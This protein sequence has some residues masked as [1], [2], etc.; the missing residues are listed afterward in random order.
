ME[1]YMPAKVMEGFQAI[2]GGSTQVPKDS[3]LTAP[4]MR[5]GDVG[6]YKEEA[7]YKQ[8]K[9][10]FGDW[11]DVQRLGDKRDYCRM[12]YPDG[13]SEND[14][15]FACALAGT[16]GMSSISYRTKAVKDGFKRSRDDYINH[17]RN[18]GRDAY[19]RILK[20]KD[21][22]YGASCIPADDTSFGSSEFLDTNPPEDIKTL[23]DF[24]RGCRM[25][26]RLRDDMVDYMGTTII[27]TAGGLA[28]DDTPRPDVTQALHFNGQDQFLRI[29][30]S[31]DLTL[32]N[33]GSLRSVRA[34]SVWV[35]FDEFTNNAH[36]FDFGNGSGVDNVFLGILG[37]G[38]AD[39]LAGNA[40]R[41]PGSCQESTIP[42]KKS[43]A[44]F[45]P[46]LSPQDLFLESSANIDEYTCDGPEVTPLRGRPILLRQETDDPN[47]TRSRATLLFEIWDSRIRKMQIKLNRAIPKGEWT[48]IVITAKD[49]DALRPDI[50][51]YINGS[52]FYTQE[53]GC[54]P[55][56]SIT[57]SNYLGKSNWTD[58]PGEY[59]LRD[60]LF[61]GSIFDFRVYNTALSETK[62]KRVLQWGMGNL[63]LQ[64]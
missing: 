43:G 32:G 33:E 27:Q 45:C 15:F 53:A 38:D 34:F 16:S 3:I 54:L 20:L 13:G 57:S 23:V 11:A 12:I 50:L 37:K 24:Y 28:V 39:S 36:I 44:Q 10:F 8:D 64:V 51:V 18:D 31:D 58:A 55:Q 19:C 7:G 26:L 56:N 6:P 25:W 1:L 29:G 9:R 60:E 22:T 63:G 52:L 21:G 61:N 30:D 46:E 14:S 41:P 42:D 2:A 59:E 35:K 62:I 40:I 5:R 48:H 17:I 49:M 4:F 47:S